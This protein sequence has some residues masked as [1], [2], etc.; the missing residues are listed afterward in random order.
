MNSKAFY[1]LFRHSYAQLGWWIGAGVSV[2]HVLF[3]QFA[4]LIWDQWTPPKPE[5][6]TPTI[7]YGLTGLY[8]NQTEPD[9]IEAFVLHGSMW[10]LVGWGLI[11]T[12][13]LKNWSVWPAVGLCVLF[14]FR[15][16]FHPPADG[17]L[18]GTG[19]RYYPVVLVGLSA[20]VAGVIWLS[21]H[22]K[23]WHAWL[24]LAALAVPCFIAGGRPSDWDYSFVFAPAYALVSGISIKDIYFQYDL[25]LSGLA[26]LFFKWHIDLNY[27]QV[28]GQASVWIFCVLIFWWAKEVFQAKQLALYLLV[29]V[30]IM[31]LFPYY[32][33]TYAEFQMS[34]LRLD[35][36]IVVALLAWKKGTDHW[37]VGL[38]LAF[39]LVLHRSFGIFYSIAYVEYIV[40]TM[41]S[42]LLGPSGQKTKFLPLVQTYVRRYAINVI[43]LGTG[44][45]VTYLIFGNVLSPGMKIYQSLKI[46][47]M[48]VAPTS[49]FWYIIGIIALTGA[50]LFRFK[51]EVSLQYR[52]AV[53]LLMALTI[54]NLFYFLGRSHEHN[55]P[56][57]S[58]P[59]FVLLF[60]WIDSLWRR[61][62]PVR[63]IRR[64]LYWLPVGILWFSGLA[65]MVGIKD[66]L[67]GM[68]TN[69]R[70]RRTI[71][72]F[73]HP[74]SAKR[75]MIRRLTNHSSKVYFYDESL[76][77]NFWYTLDGQYPPVGY[78]QP[79]SA[80]PLLT[81]LI[82]FFQNLLDEGYYLVTE[83][84]SEA[85]AILP[86]LRYTSKVTKDG[87]IVVHAISEPN[88]SLSTSDSPK[89]TSH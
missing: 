83:T 81:E 71:Y 18:F 15:A 36:W 74:S 62:I 52:E 4:E 59:V 25:L 49:F 75:A 53:F 3:Y 12:V 1:Y 85:A 54:C 14:F 21:S 88:R 79:Y 29:V 45:I 13:Y 63:S 37:S 11:K 9:G 32:T 77:K 35:W 7:A 82:P 16:G 55:L 27:F 76:G 57:T 47:F 40:L 42:E 31:R 44:L 5:T 65:Y 10:V 89:T 69:V 34:P 72:S 84:P 38:L 43:L 19:V 33:D 68:A 86:H 56:N 20:F 50:T 6:L 58:G 17:F 66:K 61:K 80:W 23:P 28:L 51:E 78:Y 48:R 39:L 41:G 46:G 22:Y 67:S 24:W 70:H 26:A 2:L 30:F 64:V 8:T 87:F 73:Q 60:V